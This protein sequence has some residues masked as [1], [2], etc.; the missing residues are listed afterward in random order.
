M[1]YIVMDL[2]W[3][4]PVDTKD[5]DTEGMPFEII[6]IGAIK[7]N[8]NKEQI[9]V[10][11]EVVKPQVYQ[12]MNYI[13]KK[14]IHLQMEELQM[15][16]DFKSVA[17]DFIHW[18]GEDSIFCTW[19]TLDLME[20]QRNMAYYNMPAL[21]DRPVKYYDV[22]KLFS[23]AYEDEKVRRSLEY[24]VDYLKME[25][26]VPFHRAFGDAYYTS[27]IFHMMNDPLVMEKISFDTYHI[28]QSEKE[29]VYIEF[30]D[31]AKYI[32]R[33]FTDKVA[34]MEDRRVSATKCY[35]CHKNIK[36]RI[37]WFTPNGK[38]YYSVGQ[39]DKHGYMKFKVRMKKG[40]LDSVFVI[41][42]SKC[43]TEEEYEK[44]RIKSSVSKNIR[45]QK[46]KKHNSND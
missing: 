1:N 13:T 27:A 17:T 41:K 9:S 30:H 8:S 3:N 38:H 33:T 29:E 18:C 31:Y 39:C 34:A 42:T 20:L 14:L 19:G 26:E 21:S 15:G 5:C 6:E 46:R 25:K 40:P 7:L 43:I 37:R 2:E 4:Q 24:A 44:L 23:I 36:R 32:S 28:P 10:F 35:I 12:E 11:S 22:Q 16:R 45:K